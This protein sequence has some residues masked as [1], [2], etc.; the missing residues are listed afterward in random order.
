MWRFTFRENIRQL[1]RQLDA[2]G[3][4]R[5]RGQIVKLLGEA[6][7]EL[8]DLERL[9]S[10]ERWRDQP[11]LRIFAD[12]SVQDAM[13]D[14]GADFGN[15]Q[16]YEQSLD[17]LVI[18]AQRNLRAEFLEHFA[19]VRRADGSACARC[20]D[21]VGPTVV[22]DVA[23]DRDF[24]PHR[25]VIARAGIRAI[26]SSPLV[27]EAGRLIGVISTLYRAPRTFSDAERQAIGRH[28]QAVCSG[29]AAHLSA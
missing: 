22:E 15:L 14:R 7:Q 27:D 26:E 25:Q 18:V 21:G 4:D 3:S 9:S 11:A 17:G 2:A 24:D 8:A 5:E 19:L 29:L 10:T 16:L 13:R 6:E 23:A 28:A 20:L 1:R 12:R